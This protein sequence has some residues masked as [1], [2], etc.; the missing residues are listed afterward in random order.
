MNTL[1]T[2]IGLLYSLFFIGLILF[3]V[4][5]VVTALNRISKSVEDIALTLRRMEI[6]ESPLTPDH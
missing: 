4:W 5:Q 1:G 3:V 2:L 6:R